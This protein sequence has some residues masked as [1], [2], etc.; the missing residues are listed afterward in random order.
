MTVIEAMTCGL[1]TF[2]TCKGG[3]AEIIID[4]VSGFHIDPNNGDEA[5]EKIANFFDKC[6]INTNYWNVVSDAGLQRIYKR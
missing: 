4:G 3:P 1:P 5:S 6:K 2:A